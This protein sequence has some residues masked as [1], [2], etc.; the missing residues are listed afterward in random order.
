MTPARPPRIALWLLDSLA[1]RN[2]ELAGDL[3]EAFRARP[4]ALWFWRQLVGAILVGQFRAASEV[5]PLKL[6][7]FPSWV[8]E[9]GS[10]VNRRLELQTRGLG[11]SPVAGVG[12]LGIIAV[13]LMSSFVQPLWWTFVG[14]GVL[15]GLATGAILVART[16]RHPP[17]AN[18]RRT[19]SIVG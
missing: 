18:Q 5:R 12:G 1:D 3:L 13:V 16:R 8:P 4:S 10:Y 17:S 11:A 9:P 15:G 14:A 6:V 7:E 19:L 2:A